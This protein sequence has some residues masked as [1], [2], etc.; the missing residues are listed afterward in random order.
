MLPP[1]AEVKAADAPVPPTA[2]AE[3][4]PAAANVAPVAVAPTA[5]KAEVK[6]A[7]APVPPTAIAEAVPAA[8]NVAPVAVAPTAAKTETCDG[9]LFNSQCVHKGDTAT[10]G[11]YPQATETPEP[12]EWLVLDI[13][14]SK[15]QMLLLSKYVLDAK[16]Y[17]TYNN[18]SF[19]TIT[20]EKCTLRT[21]LN[22]TFKTTAFSTSEQ[23]QIALTHLDNPNN[24]YY[25]TNGGNATND[26]VFLLSLA[27]AL[28]QTSGV[29]GSGK[30]FSS[31]AERK[32]MATKY[33]IDNG[34]DVSKPSCATTCANIQCST[35]W[36]LRSP[37]L[38]R[39]SAATVFSWGDV[40]HG[41]YN[42][43]TDI[44]VR[45]ALWVKY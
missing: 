41:G 14:T 7:D 11:K 9:V 18:T 23:Q 13:D 45:P 4:V 31:D 36:W 29:A 27:D 19:T 37:G 22:G 39:L 30:Y 42:V 3:A 26:Y 44:G 16:P 40:T 15:G 10:F 8:A 32:A 35:R 43:D 24:Q 17:N 28:S 25:F 6:A 34:A 20:W 2:I 33:A 5:A 21:W 1:V 38:D 12:I